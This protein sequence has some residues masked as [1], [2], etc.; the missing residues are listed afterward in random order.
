MAPPS[1]GTNNNSSSSST[2]GWDQLSKTN[3]YI[4][5]LSPS[6]TDHD[7]VKLCQP[8]VHHILSSLSA[9]DQPLIFFFFLVCSVL[10]SSFNLQWQS[11]MTYIIFGKIRIR[12]EKIIYTYY[13]ERSENQFNYVKL[14]PSI[15]KYIT[16][17]DLKFHYCRLYLN[18]A[19]KMNTQQQRM[20]SYLTACGTQQLRFHIS[21][22]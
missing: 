2:A 13:E 10:E 8:W 6:T 9:I 21:C 12:C 1:P 22:V 4:R 7:L 18:I 16:R 5:G 20:L 3:L 14:T 17:K 19:W 15:F 11:L